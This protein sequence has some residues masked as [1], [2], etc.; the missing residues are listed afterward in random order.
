MPWHALAPPDI[1]WPAHSSGVLQL[2]DLDP[3]NPAPPYR[4]I[5]GVIAAGIH[6]GAIGAPWRLPSIGYL[7]QRYGVA[8]LTASKA[9]GVLVEEGLAVYTPGWGHF[10]AES[11]RGTSGAHDDERPR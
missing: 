3:G 4:Q 1:P 10:V 6:A 7:T 11:A 9:L 5:A 2:P 8:R